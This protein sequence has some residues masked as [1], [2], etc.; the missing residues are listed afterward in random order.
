MKMV[1]VSGK[2]QGKIEEIEIG[3][4]GISPEERLMPK[5]AIAA[6]MIAFGHRSGIAVSDTLTAYKVYANSC[7]KLS[8]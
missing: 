7:R 8:V 6:A 2:V 4:P 5:M 3:F 1:K